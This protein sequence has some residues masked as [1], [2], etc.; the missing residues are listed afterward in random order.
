L[1]SN[2][3]VAGTTPIPQRPG[4]LVNYI[5]SA[6]PRHNN[7]KQDHLLGHISLISSFIDAHQESSKHDVEILKQYLNQI[8]D[9]WNRIT[10][11]QEELLDLVKEAAN[12]SDVIHAPWLVD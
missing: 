1:H 8:I 3:Q 5:D 10:N 7:A 2:E 9:A 12:L 4:K 6:N 11:V